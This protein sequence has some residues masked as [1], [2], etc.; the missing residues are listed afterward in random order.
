M[1]FRFDEDQTRFRDSVRGM[2]AKE[3]SPERLRALGTSESARS[4]EMST[5]DWGAS[6]IAR[7]RTTAG[8]PAL[9]TVTTEPT[10]ASRPPRTVSATHAPTTRTPARSGSVPSYVPFASATVAP[11]VSESHGTAPS[12][13]YGAPSEPSPPGAAVALT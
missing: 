6:T 3:C 10:G 5:P 7:L 4:P 11:E 2:L 13:A 1:D 9:F 12:V 8:S